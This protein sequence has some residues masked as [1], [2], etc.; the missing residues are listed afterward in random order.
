MEAGVK[1]K[2]FLPAYIAALG[3]MLFWS[4]TYIWYKEIYQYYN[5]VTTIFFRLII[6]SVLLL[7][8]THPFKKLQKIDKGDLKYFVLV[9]LF[10]PF[11]YFLGESYGIKYVSATLTA[12]IIA[13]IPLFNSMVSSYFLNEKITRINIFGVILSI[14]GVG[15]MIFNKTELMNASLFGI[16][17]LFLAVFSAIA[18]AFVIKKLTV[19]YNSI[20]IVTYHNIIGIFLFAVLFYFLDFRLFL[21]KGFVK[22]AWIPLVKLAVFGS[23][24]AFVLF[25]FSIKRI[26]V[27]RTSAFSNIIPVF[28]AV[29]AFFIL[30]EVITINKIAG[31]ALVISGLF[32]SQSR[33]TGLRGSL[34]AL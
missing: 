31:I 32:L 9:A 22:Q 18:L 28:T 25:T 30:G 5:P 33:I 4:M 3:A 20:S 2:P 1:G 16:A 29:L 13:T 17:M 6:S 26:G 21:E 15:L 34:Q 19:K 14:I 11:L 12:V 10:N 8:L 7:A 27:A 23:S 24:F